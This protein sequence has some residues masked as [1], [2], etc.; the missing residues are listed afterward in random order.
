M[1]V[2]DSNTPFVLIIPKNALL[3]EK[4]NGFSNIRGQAYA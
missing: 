4:V 1:R 2:P 3:V